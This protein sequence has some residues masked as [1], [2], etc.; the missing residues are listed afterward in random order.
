MSRTHILQFEL[1]L[2]FFCGDLGRPGANVLWDFGRSKNG[3]GG[4]EVLAGKKFG[5]MFAG[6]LADLFACGFA[7]LQTGSVANGWNGRFADLQISRIAE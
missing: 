5:S 4:L 2:K 6:R 7:N 1:T 3:K